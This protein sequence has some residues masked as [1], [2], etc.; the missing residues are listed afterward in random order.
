MHLV[1]IRSN[2]VT[3]T[4][5]F[6]CVTAMTYASPCCPALPNPSSWGFVSPPA[7]VTAALGSI[8]CQHQLVESP[9][10]L[11]IAEVGAHCLVYTPRRCALLPY[12]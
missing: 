2:F 11:V 8:A 9:I 3:Q 7:L 5:W 4:P 12:N 1:I 10:K 6:D